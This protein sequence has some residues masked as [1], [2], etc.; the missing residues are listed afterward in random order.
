M[1]SA[2]NI[3]VAVGDNSPEYPA[4]HL[5]TCLTING[6]HIAAHVNG[7]LVRLVTLRR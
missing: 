6:D 3:P 1:H 5:P 7:Y 2:S 4:N